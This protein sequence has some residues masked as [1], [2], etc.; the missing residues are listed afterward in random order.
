MRRSS[1]NTYALGLIYLT[2][3]VVYLKEVWSRESCTNWDLI[4][5]VVGKEEMDSSLHLAVN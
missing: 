5:L 1:I 2:V 4:D 3:I